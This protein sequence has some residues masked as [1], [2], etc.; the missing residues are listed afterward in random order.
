M[1][2]IGSKSYQTSRQILF[3]DLV[4]IERTLAEHSAAIQ[5]PDLGLTDKILDS[6]G[7]KLAH[8]VLKPW[9]QVSSGHETS[10]SQRFIK[11]GA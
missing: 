5:A 8:T 4:T 10:E 2:M 11:A 1:I 7:L 9:K 6:Q 3:S